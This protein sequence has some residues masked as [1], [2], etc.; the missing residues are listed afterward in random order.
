[1]MPNENTLKKITGDIA[2]EASEAGYRLMATAVVKK[3]VDFL[4]KDNADDNTIKS[5]LDERNPLG[6]A[7]IGFVLAAIFELTPIPALG[8]AR[9][10]LAY[11]LRVRSYEEAG[12]LFFRNLG[13]KLLA[14]KKAMISEAERVQQLYEG[15]QRP[16][17]QPKVETQEAPKTDGHESSES[18]VTSGGTPEVRTTNDAV[19][20]ETPA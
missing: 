19:P 8:D 11:N 10:R 1:M 2:D 7:I 18:P 5:F 9:N 12:E 3:A 4:K 14:F 17:N 16:Q 20:V 15:R 6:E 13:P